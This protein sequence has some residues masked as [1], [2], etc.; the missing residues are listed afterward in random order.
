MGGGQ[1]KK[2]N[3]LIDQ[4]NQQIQSD[5]TNNTNRIT[6]QQSRSDDSIYGSREN[7]NKQVSRP[8]TPSYGYNPTEEFESDD[9]MNDDFRP[10][11]SRPSTRVNPPE[12]SSRS[13]GSQQ[14][15][16][17]DRDTLRTSNYN[18]DRNEF[19]VDPSRFNL[20]SSKYMLDPRGYDA[21]VDT[22]ESSDL[23]RRFADSGGVEENRLRV[24]HP[25]FR[26]FAETGGYSD[27]DKRNIRSRATS[28][29]SSIYSGIR[30]DSA[31]RGVVQGGYGPGR[32]ALTSRLARDEAGAVGSTS[33]NA[34][35]GIMDRVHAGKQFGSGSLDRSE[36]NIQ[37]TLQR[38]RM[39][40]SSG[41]QSNEHLAAQISNANQARAAAIAQG[42][43]QL[44]SSIDR[45]ILQL[46]AQLEVS[47]ANRGAGI[48]TG[49]VNRQ[50]GQD[51]TVA[52][53]SQGQFNADRSYNFNL[54]DQLQ[55]SQG[56]GYNAGATTVDQRM[57][58]NPQRDWIGTGLQLAGAAG[59][60]ISGAGGFGGSRGGNP[61]GAGIGPGRLTP[62]QNYADQRVNPRIRF[63][64]AA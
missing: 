53:M 61:G 49:N 55:N 6:G 31:R 26:E 33:L 14:Q 29:I 4:R 17:D 23:F 62:L 57:Q 52:G 30:D 28:P 59:G 8:P 51:T 45:E 37:N 16:Q 64:R 38:G 15:A 32:S 2:T 11:N 48:E 41:L 46:H 5:R 50:F 25:Y 58:N 56:Q 13:G 21:E 43:V 47:N 10:D 24:A 63:G 3:R 60:A 27:Q 20:D 34:E 12:T 54:Q 40:G 44:A 1:K 19:N 22:E 9:F 42:N 7:N 35:L 39:F 36:G 18:V